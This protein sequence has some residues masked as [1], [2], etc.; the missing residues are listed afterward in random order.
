MHKEG[1]NQSWSDINEMP[2]WERRR[3]LELLQ[4][5]YERQEAEMKKSAGSSKSSKSSPAKY[6]R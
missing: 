6:S 5:H 1:L 4:D 2:E 3:Y